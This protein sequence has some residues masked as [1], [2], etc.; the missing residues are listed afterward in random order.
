MYGTIDPATGEATPSR[1]TPDSLDAVFEIR[2]GSGDRAYSATAQL[3]KRFANGTELSAAY[4]YTDAKD[5]MSSGAGCAR[6]R[7]SAP[8]R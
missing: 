3:E 4:T 1:R 2:N 6:T 8:R 5:R 7:T